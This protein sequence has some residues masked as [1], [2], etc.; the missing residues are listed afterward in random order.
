M[1]LVSNKR[2]MYVWRNTEALSRNHSWC[3][4]RSSY[5]IL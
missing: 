1:G 2:A 3:G 4:K 5:Y